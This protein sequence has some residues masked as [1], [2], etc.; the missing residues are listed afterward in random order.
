MCNCNRCSCKILVITSLTLSDSNLE[1]EIVPTTFNN[2][3][4]FGLLIA[5]Q[6]IPS[7]DTP[8]PVVITMNGEEYPLIKPCGNNVMSDQ[9]RAQRTYVLRVGTNPNHFTAV[10]CNSL[11]RTSFVAPQLVPTEAAN[12]TTATES[13]GS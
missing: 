11:C 1:L 12:A 5:Q 13:A 3:E 6:S 9:L 8:V 4:R 7:A 10:N 2:G